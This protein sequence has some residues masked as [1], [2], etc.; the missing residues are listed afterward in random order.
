MGSVACNR[1]Q[2]VRRQAQSGHRLRRPNGVERGP[3]FESSETS[4]ASQD[5]ASRSASGRSTVYPAEA[6]HKRRQSRRAVSS[7]RLVLDAL[8]RA[9]AAPKAKPRNLPFTSIRSLFAGRDE[10]LADLHTALLGAKGAPV[11]LTG[12]GGIGKTRLAIEYAWSREADLFGAS[13]R[14]RE[15]QR[16][17]QRGFGGADGVRGSRPARER[18]TATTRPRSAPSCAGLRPTRPG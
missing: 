4:R 15:R 1:L 12:L 6:V 18:G 10:D 2:Q 8:R 16:R 13:V 9:G 11:A 14:R 7:P 3:K 5:G 17:A